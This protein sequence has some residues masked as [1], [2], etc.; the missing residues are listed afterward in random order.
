MKCSEC[1]FEN[2]AEAIFCGNCGSKI[3]RLCPECKFPN[4]VIYNFCNKCGRSLT[5]YQLSS[6]T[7]VE[8]F[9][10]YYNLAKIKKY[11]P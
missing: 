9:C 7:I 1:N 4:P 10:D 6:G 3:E 11:R 2:S 8:T 5:S